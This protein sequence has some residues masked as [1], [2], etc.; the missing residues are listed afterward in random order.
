[1]SPQRLVRY[2]AWRIQDENMA[3]LL[4]GERETLVQRLKQLST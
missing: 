4:S 1:M 3:I 2:L